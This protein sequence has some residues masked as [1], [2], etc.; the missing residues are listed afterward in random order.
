[1]DSEVLMFHENIELFPSGY[2]YDIYPGNNEPTERIPLVLVV[3]PNRKQLVW[4]EA[5]KEDCT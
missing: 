3:I 1:M 2:S 4:V 5:T